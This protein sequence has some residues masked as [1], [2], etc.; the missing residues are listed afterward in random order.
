MIWNN[1]MATL[2]M[3]TYKG[4]AEK[5]HNKSCILN[6]SAKTIELD[7]RKESHHAACVSPFYKL[8]HS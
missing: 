1:S 5:A 6:T 8:V 4:N 2:S 3:A 7:Q